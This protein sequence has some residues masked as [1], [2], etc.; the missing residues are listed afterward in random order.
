[1]LLNK[2]QIKEA[3]DL[4]TKVVS[5]PEWGGDVRIRMMSAK[6][7]ME[8]QKLNVA[9][10]SEINV[11]VSLLIFSCVDDK[12]QL[13]FTEEDRGF[14]EDK[15]ISSLLKLFNEAINLSVLSQQEIENKAKNS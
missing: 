11:V 2:Q 9:E 3:N 8:F 6:H 15:S 14:L 1:M 7:Q 4:P 10:A 5:M 12:N 13:V